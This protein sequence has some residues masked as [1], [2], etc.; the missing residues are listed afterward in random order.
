MPQISAKKKHY[1]WL[2]PPE[3]R[4]GLTLMHVLAARSPAEHEAAVEQWTRS[5]WQ[6]WAAHHATVRQWLA[7][8]S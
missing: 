7:D 6:A 2:T 8:A 5:V 4:G 1:P 3:N